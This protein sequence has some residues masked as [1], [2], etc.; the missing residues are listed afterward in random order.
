MVAKEK[1]KVC[2]YLL[3]F[4]KKKGGEGGRRMLNL[5]KKKGRLAVFER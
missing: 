4:T 2:G 3:G 1:E 5:K